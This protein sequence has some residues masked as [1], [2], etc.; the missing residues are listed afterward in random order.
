MVILIALLL[1]RGF[2]LKSLIKMAV[3]GSQKSFSVI[4]ILLLIG[5]VMAVWM[6]AGTVSVLVYWGI[7]SIAPEYF[8]FFVY[9]NERYFCTARNIL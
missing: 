3:A 1:K 5:A 6:A 4:A 9:L 7:K 8:I 2:P